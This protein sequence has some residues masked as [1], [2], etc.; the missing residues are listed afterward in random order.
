MTQI[1]YHVFKKVYLCK[2]GMPGNNRETIDIGPY[3]KLFLTGP[4][5]LT[6]SG[7]MLTHVVKCLA[8][9]IYRGVVFLPNSYKQT[10]VIPFKVGYVY[11]QRALKN[12]RTALLLNAGRNF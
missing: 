7:K 3:L 2:V 9:S 5:H 11:N 12:E 8:K 1:Y 4:L 6:F 10:A